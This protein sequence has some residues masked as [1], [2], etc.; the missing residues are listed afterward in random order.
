MLWFPIGKHRTE[1]DDKGKHFNELTVIYNNEIIKVI[2]K[3]FVLGLL[4]TDTFT[5]M[6][7][8]DE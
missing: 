3:D 4:S 8:V 1:F 7:L 2:D 6:I 5:I